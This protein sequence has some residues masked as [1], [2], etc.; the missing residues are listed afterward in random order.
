MLSHTTAHPP[1]RR[2]NRTEA[3]GAARAPEWACR[4]GSSPHSAGKSCPAA[5]GDGDSTAPNHCAPYPSLPFCYDV[6]S[7]AGKGPG[8]VEQPLGGYFYHTTAHSGWQPVFWKICGEKQQLILLLLYK[9][10]WIH[11][12]MWCAELPRPG[13]GSSAPSMLNQVSSPCGG[14]KIRPPSG[15]ASAPRHP[16]RERRRQTQRPHSPAHP[17][18]TGWARQ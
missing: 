14:L 17:P 4:S 10:S 11:N 18:R 1:L 7:W 12:K 13:R 3:P 9:T 15:P 2:R 6:S 16:E 8:R 5:A